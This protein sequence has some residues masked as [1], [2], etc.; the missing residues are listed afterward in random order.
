MIIQWEKMIVK[1]KQLCHL[2]AASNAPTKNKQKILKAPSTHGAAE[3]SERQ[4]MSSALNLLLPISGK[5]KIQSLSRRACRTYQDFSSR[6]QPPWHRLCPTPPQTAGKTGELPALPAA[7]HRA[8]T[9]GAGCL[10][11]VSTCSM[12]NLPSWHVCS[13][14]VHLTMQDALAN[15]SHFNQVWLQLAAGS[16]LFPAIHRLSARR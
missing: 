14:L 15:Y 1:I 4:L 2:W 3:G 8:C 7:E 13:H 9:P 5:C 10:F 6:L 16:S 12:L 11:L